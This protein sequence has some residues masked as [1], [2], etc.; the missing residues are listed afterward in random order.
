MISELLSD[1]SFNIDLGFYKGPLDILFH[2]LLKKE[3]GI[4]EVIMKDI[5]EQLNERV[6]D[7][8]DFNILESSISLINKLILMKIE[9]LLFESEGEDKLDLLDIEQDADDYD[10]FLEFQKIKNLSSKLKGMFECQQKIYFMND[11]ICSDTYETM[12]ESFEVSVSAIIQSYIDLFL[13]YEE[14]P[15]KKALSQVELSVQEMRDRIL[16]CVRKIKELRFK[17]D[18]CPAISLEKKREDLALAFFTIL[19]LEKDNYIRCY[20][21]ENFDDIRIIKRRNERKRIKK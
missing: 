10:S 12:E 6:V 19:S 13:Y 15:L 2:I 14:F 16:A 11:F 20:Q 17:Q 8:I 9:S 3:I 4:D 21:E 7:R 18:L 1:S 5:V